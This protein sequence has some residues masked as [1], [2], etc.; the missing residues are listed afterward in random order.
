MPSRRMRRCLA[1]LPIDLCS[2]CPHP[3]IPRRGLRRVCCNI[4]GGGVTTT[5][6]RPAADAALD[7]CPASGRPGVVPTLRN[8]GGPLAETARGPARQASRAP[9]STLWADEVA[10][11]GV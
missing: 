1:G 3:H 4:L 5:V 10:D 6:R 11:G 7:I 2:A 9:S 8:E